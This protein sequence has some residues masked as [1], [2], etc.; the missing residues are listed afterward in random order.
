MEKDK[1]TQPDANLVAYLGEGHD[2][3]KLVIPLYKR[4]KG[5]NDFFA[6][7]S[8]EAIPAGARLYVF[9]NEPKQPQTEQ[10]RIGGG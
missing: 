9:K 10:V 6:G 3:K 4:N 2:T 1:E 8:Q 7:A 5:G